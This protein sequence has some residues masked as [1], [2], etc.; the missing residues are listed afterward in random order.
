M[1]NVIFSRAPVRICDIGGWTDTWFYPE[2]AVLNF[3]VGLYTSV[4]IYPLSFDK[5]QITSKNLNIKTEIKNLNKIVYDGRLDLLKAAIKRMNVKEGM[6]I[7]VKSDV[8]P[9][10]GTGTS[11]SV[12]VALIAA[13]ARYLKINLEPDD[14]ADLAH[15]LEVEE[16]ELESGVQDQ[17]AAANGGIN[18]MEIAY[19]SVKITPL[20]LNKKKIS[21]IEDNM[22]LVFLDSR[23][24]SD[25]HKAVINNY[26]KGDNSTLTSF[27]IMKN[28]AYDMKKT[29]FS[30]DLL[31]IGRI[32]NR[33]W[34]A[35]KK[36]HN[37]MSNRII[38]KAEKLAN[39]NGALGFKLNGAGG[40][41]SASILADKGKTSFLK[42]KLVQKGFQILPFKFDF[43]GVQTWTA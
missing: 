4:K 15:K 38:E 8:P 16:L 2:G 43:L 3:C 37:L 41:G 23:S 5:V 1:S 34:K 12:A 10:C 39:N 42:K 22:I 31:D 19:P 17:Y 11:A 27:E 9:G 13:L 35:Q 6:D 24:S 36:L 20:N 30:G 21:D 33:N 32:M 7:L 26:K 28:C 29:L 14:I 40:G 18:F 25:M